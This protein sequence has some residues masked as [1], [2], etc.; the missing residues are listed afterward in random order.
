M[1]GG[2]H[3]LIYLQ[4]QPHARLH[5]FGRDLVSTRS[6]HPSRADA[7]SCRG[8]P[9]QK[10]MERHPRLSPTLPPA[11]LYLRL[12]LRVLRIRF[13]RIAEFARSRCPNADARWSSSPAA[14]ETL[15]ALPDAAT[16][17]NRAALRS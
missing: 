12:P 17:R 3:L 11:S 2:S 1:T 5:P 15:L 14:L 7:R 4:A 13:L 6:C 9:L 10:T 16:A 8:G